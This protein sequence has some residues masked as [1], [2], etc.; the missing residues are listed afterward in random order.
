LFKAA[1]VLMPFLAQDYQQVR[2]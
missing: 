1:G 2:I